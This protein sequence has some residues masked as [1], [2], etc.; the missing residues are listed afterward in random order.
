MESP[1]KL[2]KTRKF[3]REKEFLLLIRCPETA[4]SFS[5]NGDIK[6]F[7]LA[8]YLVK[9]VSLT[10]RHLPMVPICP[11]SRECTTKSGKGP[12]RRLIEG[13]IYGLKTY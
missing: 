9:M 11:E 3:F 13:L 12:A 4:D 1:G 7:C 8:V 2:I 10:K 6:R 5:R